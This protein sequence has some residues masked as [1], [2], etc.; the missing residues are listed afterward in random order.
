MQ[1]SRSFNIDLLHRQRST[2]DYS[3]QTSLLRKYYQD[4]NAITS[5]SKETKTFELPNQEKA[6]EKVIQTLVESDSHMR[7]HVIL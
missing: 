6:E 7:P 5:V 4:K 3:D 1:K 2:E